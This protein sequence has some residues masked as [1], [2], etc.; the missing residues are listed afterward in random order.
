[1]G[2]AEEATV[3]LDSMSDDLHAAVLAGGGQSV[4][5]ALE[6]IEGVRAA[7]SHLNHEGFVILIPTDL[8]LGHFRAPFAGRAIPES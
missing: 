3:C 5:C 1:M 8:A 6:A 7:T 2:A 4:D